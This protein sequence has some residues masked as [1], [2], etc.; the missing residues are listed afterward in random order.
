MVVIGDLLLV[1]GCLLLLSL[2]IFILAGLAQK[3]FEQ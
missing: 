2:K 1:A 3:K